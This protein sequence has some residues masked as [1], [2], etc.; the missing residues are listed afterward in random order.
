MLADAGEA[1]K[2]YSVIQ[3]LANEKVPVRINDRYVIQHNKFMVIDGATVQT[4]SFNYTSAAAYRNAENVL[5]MRNAP[6]VAAS[7]EAEW[8]RLWNE[9]TELA[10]AY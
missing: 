5:V 8:R 6:A 4:G 9:G 7:Y 1:A 10:P 3:F 2:G